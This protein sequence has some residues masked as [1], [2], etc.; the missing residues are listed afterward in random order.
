M[1]HYDNKL[2]PK[3]HQLQFKVPEIVLQPVEKKNAIIIQNNS[4]KNLSM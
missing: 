2:Q 4:D 1:T 3:I